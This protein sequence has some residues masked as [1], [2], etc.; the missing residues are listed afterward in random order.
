MRMK[1]EPKVNEQTY[2]YKICKNETWYEWKCTDTQRGDIQ[3][4][5]VIQMW[6]HRCTKRKYVRMKGDSNLFEWWSNWEN[7]ATFWRGQSIF[8]TL[9]FQDCIYNFHFFCFFNVCIVSILKLKHT[10]KLGYNELLETA[11][12]VCYDWGL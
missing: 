9:T 6:M 3:E 4:R 11:I 12:F 7:E 8:F 1:D 5:K 10:V 2:K